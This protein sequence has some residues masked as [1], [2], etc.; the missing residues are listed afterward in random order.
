MELRDG[1]DDVRSGGFFGHRDFALP[2][3]I[4]DVGCPKTRSISTDG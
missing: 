1:S 4:A 2:T 3:V